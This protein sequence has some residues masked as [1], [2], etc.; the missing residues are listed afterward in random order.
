MQITPNN[1]D[2]CVKLL[3]LIDF[4]KRNSINERRHNNFTMHEKNIIIK[5]KVSVEHNVL[6]TM[7][8]RRI[9]YIYH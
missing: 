8:F 4:G 5:S 7:Y 9:T 3:Y 1:Y 2:S 6:T